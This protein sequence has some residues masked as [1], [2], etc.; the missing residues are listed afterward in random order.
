M[1]VSRVRALLLSVSAAAGLLACAS[2]KPPTLQVQGLGVGKVGLTGANVRVTFGVRNPNP[3]SLLIERF[4]YD[5]M[6]NGHRL[7]HGYVSEPVSLQGFGEEKVSSDFNLNFLSLPRTVKALLDQDRARAQA[8]GC[9][10][11]RRRRGSRSPRPRRRTTPSATAARRPP[12]V[13]GRARAAGRA[14]ASRTAAR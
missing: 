14:A 11:T 12:A 1:A 7:G 6:L 10:P 4:E 3:E 9:A 5:L 13:R 2:I 8:R